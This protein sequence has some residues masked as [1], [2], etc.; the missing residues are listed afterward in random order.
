MNILRMILVSFH[1]LVMGM[2]HRINAT[3]TDGCLYRV[4]C[5]H[6]YFY[7]ESLIAS[8]HACVCVSALYA[9]Q[10]RLWQPS[11]ECISWFSFLMRPGGL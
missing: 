10:E 7:R 6:E 9:S 1:D 3:C 4:T 8:A 2:G 11:V 5:A